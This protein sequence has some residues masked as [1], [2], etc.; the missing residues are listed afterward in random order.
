[1]KRAAFSLALAALPFGRVAAQTVVSEPATVPDLRFGFAPVPPPQPGFDPAGDAKALIA[2]TW[3]SPAAA[4]IPGD[5][6]LGS[7]AQDERYVIRIPQKWNGSLVVCGTPGTRSEFANDAIWSDFLLARGFA[8]ASSNKAIPYN[9]IAEPFGTTDAPHS[10]YPVPFDVDGL[11]AKKTVY[12]IGMLWPARVPIE[13][14]NED[15]AALVAFAQ[16]LLKDRRG[17]RPNRTY[18]VGLSNGGAQV[19]SLLER[20]PD[21][22]DGG[23]DWS[24]P[25]W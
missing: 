7:Y 19:R 25:Y 8:F 23:V 3:R 22:V 16:D 13:R 20:Y 6:F 11:E 9:I 18:A 10:I 24:A 1:M 12:R 15:F 4:P 14:W 17:M 21:A 2:P 5:Q